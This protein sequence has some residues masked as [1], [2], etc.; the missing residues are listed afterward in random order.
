[1][2]VY[3]QKGKFIILISKSLMPMRGVILGAGPSQTG[4]AH[5]A[6]HAERLEM[7]GW[8][9]LGSPEK[10]QLGNTCWSEVGR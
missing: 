4:W 10:K 7:I 8:A 5:R 2:V 3:L 1:M 9:G 6:K